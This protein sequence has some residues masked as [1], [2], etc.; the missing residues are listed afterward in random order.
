M[1]Y[2]TQ[3][4]TLLANDPVRMKSL[5]AVRDLKLPDCWVA[6]GFVRSLVW[7]HLHQR[8]HSPLPEDID[9]IWY[10]PARLDPQADV[11]LEKALSERVSGVNWSVKNQARMH[12]RNDDAP[13]Q[14]AAHAMTCWPE[15]A[16]AV[17]VRLGLRDEIEVLAPLGLDD[18]FQLVVR[19]TERFK[20]E[21]HGM[22]LARIRAKA[23][24][25]R[26]PALRFVIEP[27]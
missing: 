26:W 4:L 21:K 23:W 19:P 7:D 3:L 2:E 14:S 25:D 12:R 16:T 9:V 8:S 24:P 10:D 1:T 11:A 18:L 20:T 17:G 5:R 13:Y 15:T 6:A 22:F 27:T